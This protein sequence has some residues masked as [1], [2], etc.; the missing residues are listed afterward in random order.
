MKSSTRLHTKL[1]R[2]DQ[3]LHNKHSPDN[4]SK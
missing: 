4:F 1:L 3:L 2:T